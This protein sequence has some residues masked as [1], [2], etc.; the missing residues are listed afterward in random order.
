MCGTFPNLSVHGQPPWDLHRVGLLAF[1]RRG[2]VV[3]ALGLG[4]PH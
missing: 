1:D 3:L 4:V 2:D